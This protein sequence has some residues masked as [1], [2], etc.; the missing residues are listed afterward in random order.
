MFH[1]L[2]R[3]LHYVYVTVWADFFHDQSYWSSKF[4]G[5]PFWLEIFGK[6]VLIRKEPAASSRPEKDDKNT[7]VAM[8]CKYQASICPMCAQ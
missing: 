2:K 5:F 1:I 7:R 4:K 8:R 3:F 6:N